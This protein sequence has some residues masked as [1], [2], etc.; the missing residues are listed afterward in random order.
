MAG[1]APLQVLWDAFAAGVY[2]LFGL[3]HLD[4][5]RRRPERRAH[6]WLAGASASALGVDVSGL[7]LRQLQPQAPPALVALNLLGVAGA[8]LCLYELAQAL[9]ERRTGRPARALQAVLAGLAVAAA[10]PPLRGVGAGALGL[11]AAFLAAALARV[12]QATRHGH[13]E[14][15]IVARGFVFLIACL[16]ADVAMELGLVPNLPGLPALG[17]IV[18]FLASARSLADRQDHEQR[19]LTELRADLEKR[20]DERT[21]ALQELNQRL[22]AASRSDD[23][24]GLA[25]R[26]AFTEA[27]EAELRRARRSG[28]PF[29]IV[30]AD[31]DNFKRVNDTW[32][33]AVGDAVLRAVAETVR[34]ALRQQD[35]VARWGGEELILL[36]CETGAAG[37][38]RA[39]ETVRAAVEALRVEAAGQS[40]GVTLSLGVAAHEGQRSLDDT[41][42][43]A[44][45]ALYRAKLAGRNRVAAAD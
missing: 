14:A 17:F 39:A 42:G 7:A 6:L 31:V 34:G 30:L 33:H 5:W 9:G 43:E 37:A 16:L 25:N 22:A 45:R 18:L 28:R 10:A 8:T 21:L 41:I 44:D 13:R 19:E 1:M 38:E 4:I 11:A 15:A 40:I 2:V 3:V 23:L 36:L 24:T 20:V 29:S 35:L 32:G 12:V 26:R 27:S